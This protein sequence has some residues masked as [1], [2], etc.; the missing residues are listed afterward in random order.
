M[1]IKNP[2]I[3]IAASTRNTILFLSDSYSIFI[4]DLSYSKIGSVRLSD[5]DYF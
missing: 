1:C 2:I 3:A 4:L 5:I